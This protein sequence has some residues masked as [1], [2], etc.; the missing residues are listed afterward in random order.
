MS[1][2]ARP[3]AAAKVA[4]QAR[5]LADLPWPDLLEGVLVGSP[6]GP[7]VLLGLD[8]EAARRV[9]GVVAVFAAGDLP[10]TGAVDHWALGQTRVGLA[11]PDLAHAG[12]P[13]ALVVA[14]DRGAAREAARRVG[15]RVRTRPPRHRLDDHLD[16]AIAI[17]DW[18][19]SDTTV[20]DL[21]AG[22][23]EADVVVE[24]EYRTASRHHAALE[25]AGAV[26]RWEG[27]ALELWTATQWVYGV[28]AALAQVLGVPVDRVRV[29]T[30][31]V[32]GGFGAKGSAWPHEV[33]AALAARALGR[34]VRIL[35]DRRQSFTAHGFQPATVQRI[36]LAA[37]RDGTL[38]AIRHHGVSA[39]AAG[40][41]YVEHASLGSRGM[42]ACPNIETRDRVVR[43]DLPQPTFMRAPHEGP[44]MV[45][46]EIAMDELAWALGRDPLALRLANYAEADPTSGRPFSSKAL[47]ECYTLAAERFGWSARVPEPGAQRRGRARIGFGM[48]SALMTTFRS[49]ANARVTLERGGTLLV[50]SAAHDIGSGIHAALTRIAAEP[51]GLDPDRVEVRLG[52]TNLPEAGGTFGSSA[53]LSVGSAVREA[54]VALRRRLEELGGEPGLRPEEYDEVLALRRLE[55]VSEAATW[56]PKRDPGAWAMNAYGAVFVEVRVDEDLPVPRVTRVVGAYSAGRIIS[57]VTARSQVVGGLIWGLGQALLEASPVDP[58]TGRFVATALSGYRVPTQADVPAIEVLFAE[59]SDPRASVIGARGVGEIG[60]IGIGAAIANAVYHATGIR[61]REVPI[62]VQTLLG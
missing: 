7:G 59:E 17:E 54:A 25:P 13:V 27:D 2:A 18:M 29:R 45:G 28:R 1:A 53:T 22:L 47:R 20:G 33:L 38:T 6:R 19:P 31:P 60:T 12:E 40:E 39:A 14:S 35:L 3:D 52:D 23:A 34:P 30:G 16:E 58:A 56:T 10:A 61:V 41:D 49:A 8:L 5:Y 62:R 51:L 32:G 26:A 55:R 50:E 24:G 21:A 46:L 43:L 37:R 15:V 11:G 44:G 36:T 48:A 57:P 42:Y 4:G 9:P